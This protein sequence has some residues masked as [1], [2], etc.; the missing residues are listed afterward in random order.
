MGRIFQ[1]K[2]TL[3]SLVSSSQAAQKMALYRIHHLQMDCNIVP[4]HLCCYT[5]DSDGYDICTG[6]N[7]H[8]LCMLHIGPSPQHSPSYL[9]TCLLHKGCT[10][11]LVIHLLELGM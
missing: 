9:N 11:V 2:D 7:M 5:A 1:M 4:E 3:L 8:E 10:G 6:Q